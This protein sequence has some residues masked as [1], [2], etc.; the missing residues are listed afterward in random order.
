MCRSELVL[1]SLSRLLDFLQYISLTCLSVWYWHLCGFLQY[2]GTQVTAD[3]LNDW[4]QGG[5]TRPHCNISLM[6]SVSKVRRKEDFFWKPFIDK[7]Q[8]R[9]IASMLSE[10]WFWASFF[11]GI[12]FWAELREWLGNSLGRCQQDYLQEGKSIGSRATVLES[13][14]FK[15]TVVG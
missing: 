4:D 13:L 14:S 11:T 6:L 10:A 1:Y 9:S 3:V 7:H 8:S 12:W 15:C 2:V 5:S